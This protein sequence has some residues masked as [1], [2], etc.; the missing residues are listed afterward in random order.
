MNKN[1]Y[2]DYRKELEYQTFLKEMEEWTKRKNKK[3]KNS[4]SYKLYKMLKKIE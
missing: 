2:E 4:L 3:I 1:K